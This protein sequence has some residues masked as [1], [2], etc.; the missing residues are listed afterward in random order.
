MKRVSIMVA[1]CGMMMI[2]FV[3][4]AQVAPNANQPNYTG[5]PVVP[6][7]NTGST[8]SVGYTGTVRPM[9]VPGATG[10]TGSTGVTGFTPGGATTPGTV[11]GTVPAPTGFT[12]YTGG[13]PR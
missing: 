6:Q 12:G 3:W 8:G 7:G 2:T 1:V 4:A 10:F 13:P 5:N 11:P 9:S